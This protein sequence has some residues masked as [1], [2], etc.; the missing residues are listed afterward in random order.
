MKAFWIKERHNPQLGVY[1]V[2]LGQMSAKEAR[3]GEDS[4][5]GY[6]YTHKFTTKAAYEAEIERLKS[7][8]KSVQ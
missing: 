6:N 1:F 3:A 4:R 8:G 2:R 5:Y 7:I